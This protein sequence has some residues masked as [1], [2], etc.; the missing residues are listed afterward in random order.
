VSKTHHLFTLRIRLGK[1]PTVIIHAFEAP[2]YQYS[3]TGHTRIDVE[4]RQGGK[5]IFSLG[6]TYC[7]VP[8][9]TSL[10]GIEA[11]ALV[12]SLVAMRPGDT[13]PSYFDSYTPEQLAWAKEYGD[14]LNCE[15]ERR[16]CDENGEVER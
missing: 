13:D 3:A 7:A 16:Y 4:V 11:K 8:R 6:D 5:T 14:F 12:L 15:K 2:Y 9:G 10:D 1:A